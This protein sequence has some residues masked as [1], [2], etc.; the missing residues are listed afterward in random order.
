MIT[1]KQ[2]LAEVGDKNVDFKVIKSSDTVYH[3]E[4]KING[5]TISFLAAEDD[6]DNNRWWVVF[7]STA[8]G[9]LAQ[10]GVTGAGGEFEVASFVIAAMKD[11]IRLNDPKSIWF[12]ADKDDEEAE[13]SVRADVYQKLIKRKFPQFTIRRTDDD[14]RSS[15][16][17]LVRESLLEVADKKVDYEVTRVNATHFVTETEIN[18]RKLKFKAFNTNDLTEG[19]DIEFEEHQK[20]GDEHIWT[21]KASGSG[22]EFEVAAFVIASMKEF[23]STYQP[24]KMSFTATKDIAAKSQNTRAAAYER[25]VRRHFPEYEVKRDNYASLS[26][27]GST[28]SIFYMTLRDD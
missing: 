10:Q 16:F 17:E 7:S 20:I 1:F 28:S 8:K 19:W 24:H 6:P 3:A 2:F 13:K 22:G 15:Y 26:V 23:V 11:F 18:G 25:L 12:T 21:S 5:R 27:Q 9:G 14:E 4:R